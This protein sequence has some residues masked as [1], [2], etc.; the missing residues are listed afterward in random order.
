ML[1]EE[2]LHP[3]AGVRQFWVTVGEK[4]QP[5]RHAE[6]QQPQRPKGIERLH[7]KSSAIRCKNLIRTLRDF[8]RKARTSPASVAWPGFQVQSLAI[9]EERRGFMTKV[10]TISVVTRGADAAGMNRVIRGVARPVIS[11]PSMRAAGISF[12]GGA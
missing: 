10:E 11:A 6:N 2:A 5:E 4:N 1:H 8:S 12:G 7:E 3:R 9:H